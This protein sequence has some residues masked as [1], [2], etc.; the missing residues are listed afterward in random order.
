MYRSIWMYY[1][2][3]G[4]LSFTAGLPAMDSWADSLLPP[5]GAACH[6]AQA[7][8]G[9]SR[10]D[11]S[12]CLAAGI[13]EASSA[14]ATGLSLLGDIHQDMP[15]SDWLRVADVVMITA[16]LLAAALALVWVWANSMTRLAGL[17]LTG[18][19]T[20]VRA[21]GLALERRGFTSAS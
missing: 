12:L 6:I 20:L 16:G 21:V 5:E 14:A 3:T 4:L 13:A 19:Y 2:I 11:L 7:L 18:T 9:F 1:F 15:L 8:Q 17:S 10:A